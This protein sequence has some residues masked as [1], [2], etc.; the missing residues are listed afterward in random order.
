MILKN[1]WSCFV[2]IN[3]SLMFFKTILENF[4]SI[5][6]NNTDKQLITN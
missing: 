3:A 5:V 4:V 6:A 2:V 1:L